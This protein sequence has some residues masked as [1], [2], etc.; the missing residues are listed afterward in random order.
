MTTNSDSSHNLSGKK[1]AIIAVGLFLL[2]AA[3]YMV[4]YNGLPVM[5]DE[6][7]Y[8]DWTQ[9]FVQNPASRIQPILDS[10]SLA[11][12]LYKFHRVPFLFVMAVPYK[13][14]QAI[15]GWGVVHTMGV[16]SLFLTALAGVF[17]FLTGLAL[18]Y[19]TKVAL[20]VSLVFGLGTPAWFY[21]KTYV[22][23]PFAGMWLIGGFFFLILFRKRRSFWALVVSLLFFLLAML[24]RSSRSIIHQDFLMKS[25]E[26]LLSFNPQGTYLLE[27]M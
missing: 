11:Q 27:Q 22:R 7:Y 14:A 20:F 25:F 12:A 8:A 19:R 3:I 18:G 17:V 5:V 6:W 21:S 2:L 1:L 15:G 16:T 13:I 9:A 26:G 24:T 10:G 4:S 23:E